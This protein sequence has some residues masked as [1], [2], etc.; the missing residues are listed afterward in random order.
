MMGACGNG[1]EKK[2]TRPANNDQRI[3]R[4]TWTAKRGG[5]Q[6]Q[7][8][9]PSGG[10]AVRRGKER[11]RRRRLMQ[12]G[13]TD[14]LGFFRTTPSGRGCGVGAAGEPNSRPRQRPALPGASATSWD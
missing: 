3:L 14:G 13:Q 10:L 7:N 9:K 12:D 5:A 11:K 8:T 4:K 2:R 6:K 1:E